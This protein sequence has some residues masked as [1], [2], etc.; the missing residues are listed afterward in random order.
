[1]GLVAR[2][3]ELAVNE[4]EALEY[5]P[6]EKRWT[7]DELKAITATY[8]AKLRALKETACSP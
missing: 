3:G 1:V 7:V 8:R 4:L 2:I 5:A 6:T